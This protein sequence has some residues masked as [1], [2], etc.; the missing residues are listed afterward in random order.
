MEGVMMYLPLIPVAE[1]TQ[2]DGEE[3]RCTE[4]DKLFGEDEEVAYFE[5]GYCCQTCAEERTE[6]AETEAKQFA[7]ENCKITKTL[8]KY[9]PTQ[10]FRCSPDDYESGSRE[11]YTRNS[12]LCYCRHNCTNYDD[13]IKGLD[14]CDLED[15]IAY[16]AIRCRIEEL[17]RDQIE[18][19]GDELGEGE[20][21][22]N[23]V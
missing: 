9:D 2:E 22:C 7:E 14:K 16:E 15:Q 18:E 13:L 10:E 20:G 1:V 5:D 3:L 21:E 6:I 8:P 23:D 19:D 17:L 11:S 4:C 12:H